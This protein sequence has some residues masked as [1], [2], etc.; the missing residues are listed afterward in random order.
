M[1]KM[2]PR[3]FICKQCGKAGL[4]KPRRRMPV[5]CT[6]ECEWAFNTKTRRVRDCLRC[7][8]S[9]I[10]QFEDATY[11]SHACANKGRPI[12]RK[13]T[14]YRMTVMPDGRCIGEHRAVIERHWGRILGR[15]ETVHH[16]NGD[17]L[18]NRLQNLELISLADHARLHR[19]EQLAKGLRYFPKRTK[20]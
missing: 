13:V 9:F 3:E 5:F 8:Q 4:R 15:F 7:G 2:G 16:I 10:S 20:A 17:K 18:D 6:R 12:D 14:R 11:C 19:M 1:M